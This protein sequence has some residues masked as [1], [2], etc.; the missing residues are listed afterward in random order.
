MAAKCGTDKPTD[1]R[2]D[3]RTGPTSNARF[4]YV[5]IQ[6]ST[7]QINRYVIPSV[8]TKRYGHHGVISTT[9]F[10]MILKLFFFY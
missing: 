2:T 8:V 3:I 4:T 10:Y 1:R 6:N 9:Q 7:F 5:A